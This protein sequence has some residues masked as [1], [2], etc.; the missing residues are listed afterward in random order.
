M[1]VYAGI[2]SRE[3]PPDVLALMKELGDHL[4]CGG[5]TLRTGLAPGA[6]QAFALGH[7]VSMSGILPELYLPWASFEESFLRGWSVEARLRSPQREAFSVAKEHHPAWASL[8]NG[9]RCLHARNV[10][11]IVGP[12]VS[13]P[14]LSRF[15]ICWTPG[16][17]GGGGTGQ[18]IRL[19]RFFDV[20]V[21]DLADAAARERVVGLLSS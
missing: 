11:Q 15:V 10:H 19:A 9:A 6:D 12:D 4:A 13:A 8:S 20:P 7:M 17:Q 18:A 21:F 1:K 5:W 2:G 14:L 3:T 16:A